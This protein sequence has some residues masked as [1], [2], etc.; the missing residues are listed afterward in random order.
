[1]II[2]ITYTHLHTWLIFTI[3]TLCGENEAYQNFEISYCLLQPHETGSYKE[4]ER[5]RDKHEYCHY[6][7]GKIS[8]YSYYYEGRWARLTH[9]HMKTQ[10]YS[11]KKNMSRKIRVIH[12]N[13]DTVYVWVIDEFM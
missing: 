10:A 9:F 8:I 13:D 1:M 3:C 12:V 6:F 7:T 11:K 4:R 5:E 2:A